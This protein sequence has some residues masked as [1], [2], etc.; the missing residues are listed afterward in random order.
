MN[1]WLENGSLEES[2]EF[3][4][5]VLDASTEALLCTNTTGTIL[6][7]NRQAAYLLGAATG[8]LENES[9]DRYIGSQD[10][11]LY[12]RL[13][14]EVTDSRSSSKALRL[15]ARDQEGN[16]FFAEFRMTGFSYESVPVLVHHLRK[17]DDE[18]R[19]THLPSVQET[20]RQYGDHAFEALVQN[21]QHHLPRQVG[22]IVTLSYRALRKYEQGLVREG[23]ANRQNLAQVAQELAQL[24]EDLGFNEN[25]IPG[26]A[27]QERVPLD[28]VVS[29][30]L[31]EFSDVLELPQNRLV[32]GYLPEVMGNGELLYRLFKHLIG[33]AVKYR[34]QRVPLVVSIDSF[35]GGNGVWH[36]LIKDNGIGFDNKDADRI[37]QPFVQ[38]EQEK[39]RLG[40]G[41]GLT[42]CHRIVQALGGKISAL[43]EKGEGTT[44]IVTFPGPAT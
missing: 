25:L 17:V 16:E 2:L 15:K 36:V 20:A 30:V 5:G 10:R 11:G 28:Y 18:T 22:E 19:E 35:Q 27:S 26:P 33:N 40:A 31:S 7:A 29:R 9:I 34:K 43:S 21:L 39:P 3:L 14:E 42:I 44:L 4:K 37:F 8:H 23:D 1:A 24:L 6:W 12:R 13:I 38:L 32:R 41:L